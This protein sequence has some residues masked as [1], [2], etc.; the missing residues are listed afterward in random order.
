MTDCLNFF[1]TNTGAEIR[2]DWVRLYAASCSTTKTSGSARLMSPEHQVP[3]VLEDMPRKDKASCKHISYTNLKCIPWLPLDKVLILSEYAGQTPTQTFATHY[4]VILYVVT[5]NN[6]LCV[7]NLLLRQPSLLPLQ[8]DRS[9]GGWN[10]S[11]CVVSWLLKLSHTMVSEVEPQQNKNKPPL[12][13]S[14]QQEKSVWQAHVTRNAENVW[15]MD[16]RRLSNTSPTWYSSHSSWNCVT[17]CD[18]Q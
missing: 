13:L 3:Q 10:V 8:G 17:P 14:F 9:V 18:K 6:C 5:S 15:L 1:K 4:D 2:C 11:A 12:C 7:R 16:V